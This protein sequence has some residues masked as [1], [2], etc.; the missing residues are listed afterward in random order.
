M[1]ARGSLRTVIAATLLAGLISSCG[2]GTESSDSGT[3]RTRNATVG[4]SD[5]PTVA[6]YAAY[7]GSGG[8]SIYMAPI[9]S[10]GT[11]TP[12]ELATDVTGYQTGITGF[13]YKS[14]TRT[15]YWATQE[16]SAAKGRSQVIG[17]PSYTT[18]FVAYGTW[19]TGGAYDSSTD[20][21]VFTA[22][23]LMWIGDAATSG[24]PSAL[25]INARSVSAANGKAYTNVLTK[26]SEIN[27]S[28]SAKR[29]IVGGVTTDTWAT[30]VDVANGK[31]YFATNYA[32]S[33]II[34]R[35]NVDGSG[36]ASDY[37]TPTYGVVG[38]AMKSDGSLV[39]INGQRGGSAP[40]ADNSFITVMN[41]DNT[42]SEI[43]TP[44]SNIKM[45]AIWLVEAPSTNVDPSVSGDGKTGST[46]TC[47]DADWAEDLTG[48]RLTR[49]PEPSRTYAWYLNGA[50]VSGETSP[51]YTA[52][53]AG[54]LKC[55][56]AASNLAGTSTVESAEVTVTA[57]AVPATESGTGTGETASSG[58]T[59][60]ATTTT[61][62][63]YPTIKVKFTY[64]S[65]KK[66]MKATFKKVSGAK[67]YSMAITGATKK[68]VKCTVSKSTVTC[69]A[70][71]KKGANTLTIN[72][73]NT[74][75]AIVAQKIS[76][77]TVR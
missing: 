63:S 6:L 7:N 48:Q 65:S 41:P 21:Y 68:T 19:P 70:T 9:D 3:Q 51:T 39:Y 26:M 49:S 53:T 62:P 17:A 46:Y 75:K 59:T 1:K 72:A 15:L 22:D 33:P 40:P 73:K 25:S 20:K 37:L 38:L 24:S 69:K 27:L 35:T 18:M 43:F 64:T 14:S 57:P 50:V 77:K 23:G 66:S 58:S 56:V 10:A 2:T 36:S 34:R 4:S 16:L 47:N 44:P 13:G 55:S 74:A 32:S 67:T 29:D 31:L 8:S 45:T 12:T 5:I 76:S 28:T 71:L 11:L 52:S 42:S 60:S 61:I 30:I 54:A